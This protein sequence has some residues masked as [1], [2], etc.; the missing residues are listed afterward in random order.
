MLV[1]GYVECGM[2]VCEMLN[3]ICW[4]VECGMWYVGMW[5]CDMLICWYV[6]C[7]TS[8]VG[9]WYVVCWQLL[10]VGSFDYIQQVPQLD[11]NGKYQKIS[12]FQ[13]I[14]S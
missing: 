12:N 10:E 4:Y 5:V 2:L 7:G 1:C 6:I 9:M 13:G 3:V 14:Q 11:S 8:N